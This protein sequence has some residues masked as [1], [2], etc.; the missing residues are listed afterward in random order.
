MILLV[1][2]KSAGKVRGGQ[3]PALSLYLHQVKLLDPGIFSFSSR[4]Q[5]FHEIDLNFIPISAGRFSAP[6]F[7]LFFATFRWNFFMYGN[8]FSENM[9]MAET[10]IYTSF[11]LNQVHSQTPRVAWCVE[12]LM[13]SLQETKGGQNFSIGCDKGQMIVLGRF[14]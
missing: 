6:F 5:I 14:N 9:V 7:L 13:I 3:F 10:K 11:W 1:A 4:D 12:G 2:R 8:Y